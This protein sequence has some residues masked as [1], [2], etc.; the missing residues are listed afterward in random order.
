MS[1]KV[2][3][4][5]HNLV[6]RP[7]IE[8]DDEDCTQYQLIIGMNYELEHLVFVDESAFNQNMSH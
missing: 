2:G 8:R 4:S 7:A 5:D 6:T 3:K 1:F